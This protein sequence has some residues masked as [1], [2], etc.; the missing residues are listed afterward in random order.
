MKNTKLWGEL[1]FALRARK[2]EWPALAYAE[3]SSIVLVLD[4]SFR[5]KNGLHARRGPLASCTRWM[6]ND[7]VGKHVLP[8]LASELTRWSALYDADLE[9]NAYNVEENMGFSQFKLGSEEVFAAYFPLKPG[10][11]LCLPSENVGHSLVRILEP[12]KG[13]Q[14]L[15]MK[16]PVFSENNTN[17]TGA[18]TN[19]PK[20]L[21]KENIEKNVLKS[22]SSAGD[23]PPRHRVLIAD[24]DPLLARALKRALRE[25]FDVQVAQG[26]KG[27]LEFLEKEKYDVVLC[28][29]SMPD[30]SGEEVF[31]W[32]KEMCPDQL[33]S[34]V[35]MTGGAF[36]DA[37]SNF[38][39]AVSN[40]VVD[41][42]FDLRDLREVLHRHALREER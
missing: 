21:A 33:S 7:H 26:G 42:P 5:V 1:F 18:R 38:L 3:S 31:Q 19:Q 34:F 20:V 4:A 23:S 35:F 14:N 15:W 11:L 12:L 2:V 39:D 13:M 25:S 29:L 30:V 17:A 22:E 40:P 6:P 10:I 37:T 28:D 9:Q 8:E 27:A 41:K 16:S 36:S 24:D 32:A